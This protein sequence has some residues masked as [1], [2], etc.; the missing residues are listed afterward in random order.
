MVIILMD[1]INKESRMKLKILLQEI[2]NVNTKVKNGLLGILR[3][4]DVIIYQKKV[5]KNILKI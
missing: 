1:L 4:Y 5:Y 3:E 2:I